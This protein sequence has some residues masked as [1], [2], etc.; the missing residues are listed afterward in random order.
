MCLGKITRASS[1]F[2]LNKVLLLDRENVSK[3]SVA[4]SQKVLGNA[5]HVLLAVTGV[6]GLTIAHWHV[7][8]PD[9][10]ENSLAGFGDAGTTTSL[11]GENAVLDSIVLVVDHEHVLLVADSNSAVLSSLSVSVSGLHASVELVA[12]NLLG[13][14]IFLH[15]VEL[16]VS[17]LET[18]TGGPSGSIVA[19]NAAELIHVGNGPSVGSWIEGVLNLMNVCIPRHI[20]LFYR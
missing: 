15:Q 4:S 9:T 14:S 2:L 8:T 17:K 13:G 16:V 1:P 11:S 3:R 12:W 10:D 19:V 7:F 20:D 6:L 18:L 5:D